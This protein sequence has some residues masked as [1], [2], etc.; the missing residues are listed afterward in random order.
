MDPAIAAALPQLQ[1]PTGGQVMMM[2]TDGPESDRRGR[3]KRKALAL[4]VLAVAFYVGF[5]IVHYL[6]S[7][8]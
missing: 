3:L 6:R 5:I 7:V 1:Y 4:G 2:A 8:S